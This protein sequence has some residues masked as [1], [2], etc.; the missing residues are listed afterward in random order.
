MRLWFTLAVVL[1]TQMAGWAQQTAKPLKPHP[2]H[3]FMVKDNERKSG[4]TS[5]PPTATKTNAQNLQRIERE[6]SPR[7]ASHSATKAAVIKPE[8]ETPT[9]KINFNGSG[10]QKT[11]LTAQ[12]PNPYKGRLK[13]KG[14]RNK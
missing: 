3:E 9:P 5:T 8:K 6:R 14:T 11:G 10:A 2:S 12:G 7:A 13:G 4:E 1:A